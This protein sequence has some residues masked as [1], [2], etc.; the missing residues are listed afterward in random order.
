LLTDYTAAWNEYDGEAFL[1][2]VTDSYTFEYAGDVR[3]ASEQAS[4]IASLGAFDWSVETIG[5][6]IV[7]GDGPT[8]L[9]AS[10][11]RVSN[12]IGDTDGISVSTIVQDGFT[13]RVAHHLNVGHTSP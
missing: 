12:N 1:A 10:A 8:Y 4:E 6:R 2:L 5:D 3:T 13:Y 7:S 11:D 9:V